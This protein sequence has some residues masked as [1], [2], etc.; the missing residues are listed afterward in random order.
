MRE[1]FSLFSGVVVTSTAG[2]RTITVV[3]ESYGKTDKA[4]AGMMMEGRLV[5]SAMASYLGFKDYTIPQPG[6]RVL[7]VAESANSCYVIGSLPQNTAEVRE[8]P[9][10][11][12]LGAGNALKD[13]SN[14]RG[15]VKYTTYIPDNRRATDVVDGEYVVGNELGVLLGLYQELATLK[16][17]EIAQVQCHLLDDLVRIISHNFQHYSSLGE[18]NIWHDGK[19]IMS[20]FGA[21]HKPA[22]SYGSTA[23]N[24]ENDCGPTFSEDGPPSNPDDSSD[25]YKISDDEQT[26]AISRFKVFLGSVA[27]FLHVFLYRPA[28]SVRR[29]L[30]GKKGKPDTGLCDI[31]IGTDGGMHVRSVKEVFIEKTQW[32]RVP[33]RLYNPED[34]KGDDMESLEYEEKKKFEFKDDYKYKENPFAYALQIRDYVAYINEKCSYQ[35]FKKMEKD[36]YVND[37]LGEEDTI[38]DFG[39]IDKDTKMFLEKYE[40]RTAGI[41]LMPNG[42]ITIRDAWNSAIVMEGGNISIQPAKDLF[43][44]PLRNCVT[45]A[46]GSYNMA[47]KKHIDLSSS[48]EGFRLKTEKAQY[49]YSDKGGI[50]LESKS[51]QDTPGKPYPGDKA[52]ED[53][54]GIV[55]KSELGIY[56]YAKKN[57]LLYCKKDLLLESLENLDLRAKKSITAYGDDM[58]LLGDKT[59]IMHSTKDILTIADNSVIT[60]GAKNTILGQKDQKL[61]V[62]YDKDS[63]FI[64]ILYGLMDVPQITSSFG[65]IR[66]SKKELI[67]RTT[68]NKEQKFEDLKFHYLKS[69]QYGELK[70]EEDAIPMTLPQQEDL[71]SGLYKLEEWKEKEINETLPYPGK[72]K[73]ENFYLKSEKPKNLEPNKVGKDY[74]N[75]AKSESQPATIK[76][77][78]LKQYKVQKST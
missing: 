56:G 46:G 7:C 25:Y 59:F 73:F 75:K 62:M 23:V 5:S 72:D 42:G 17:S 70:P 33:Q 38:K 37:Q 10:R 31:H 67:K 9:V 63:M 30:S 4:D 13:K 49:L 14:R 41:Y 60:A 65:K 3:R 39:K 76:L 51:K 52:I 19:K 22:E 66:E 15:H 44:Q 1:Q 8:L 18:Y 47:C 11:A 2:S 36:F 32:I 24:G 20:E 6:T 50:V 35:N 40:L 58:Y 12:L 45:K 54:G 43:L 74:N 61:G 53:V 28:P 21:T 26:Q 55:L 16:A 29:Y 77:E 27:D 48:E 64:D 78:S 34:P 69:K 71:L 68:F 57:I